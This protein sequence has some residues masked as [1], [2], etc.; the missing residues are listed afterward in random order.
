MS[1]FRF[2]TSDKEEWT[3]V[4]KGSFYRYIR[5]GGHEIEDIKY[6]GE[7]IELYWEDFANDV[8]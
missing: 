5:H 1:N 2:R 6:E 8:F 3:A 7:M 4:D